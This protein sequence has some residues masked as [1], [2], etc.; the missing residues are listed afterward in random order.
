MRSGEGICSVGWKNSQERKDLAIEAEVSE[1]QVMLAASPK[2]DRQTL[3]A[4]RGNSAAFRHEN[5][6]NTECANT[7]DGLQLRQ[8]EQLTF[9]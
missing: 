5:L 3:S 4:L 8:M 9:R 7:S 2:T 6:H 1:L